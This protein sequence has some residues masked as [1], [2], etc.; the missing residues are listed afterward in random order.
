MAKKQFSGNKQNK[1]KSQ[2]RA[3]IVGGV[4]L[5][6]IIAAGIL[7][8]QSFPSA[9]EFITVA[10][11]TW[12]QPD[13]K[14]LGPANAAVVVQEFSDFQCPYCRQ[15]HDTILNKLISQYVATG[16]IRFEYHHFIV[17]DGNTGGNESR[18]AAEAS[19]CANEQGQFWDYHN[20]LFANQKS[21]GSGTFSDVRLRAFAASL[22]LD[23]TKFNSCFNSG[24]LAALVVKDE[25]LATSDKLQT[26]PALLVNGVL[27]QNPIDYTIVQSA[28][29][30]ALGQH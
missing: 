3:I 30:K 28:I 18:R 10:K 21:E 24:K 26:T 19:E 2:N 15:F 4:I 12:P 22:G 14:A 20:M 8:M 6:A 11:Q 7:I 27:V 9:G 25:N 1:K 13:G 23:T 29:D 17:I 5:L 16:K